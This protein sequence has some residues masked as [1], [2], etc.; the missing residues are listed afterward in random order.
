MFV[1]YE[2]YEEDFMLGKTPAVPQEEFAFYE[3]RAEETLDVMT[4]GRYTRIN[5]DYIT[6]K[7]KDA[8]CKLT[9][10]YYKADVLEQKTTEA[11]GTGVMTSYSNDGQSASF[12][13]EKSK[14]TEKNLEVA[15]GN[16]VRTALA[17]T[18]LLYAGVPSYE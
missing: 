2:Y 15:A 7:V 6:M 14:Y 16:I 9:E 12:D 18:G 10:L 8:I 3:K 13:V 11:G 4:K 1:T 17:R 5:D